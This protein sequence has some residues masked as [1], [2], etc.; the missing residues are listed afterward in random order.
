MVEKKTQPQQLYLHKAVED[1]CY[2]DLPREWQWSNDEMKIFSERKELYQHQID[3]LENLIRALYGHY[4]DREARAPL[5]DACLRKGMNEDTFHIPSKERKVYQV[6]I[7]NGYTTVDYNKDQAD[8]HVQQLFNR[9]CL[10]MATGSGKSLV[11]IKAIALI[12][13]LMG[14]G[15]LPSRGYNIMLLFPNEGLIK[16]T[17]KQ[18]LE[19]NRGKDRAIRPCELSRFNGLRGQLSNDMHVFYGRS[20]LLTEQKKE[21]QLNYRDYLNHGKWYIFMDEAHRGD[22]SDSL[23]KAYVSALSRQGF[24]FNFSATFTEDLD[25]ATT[26]YDLSLHKF[27]E[28]GYGKQIYVSPS[29]FHFSKQDKAPN[30]DTKRKEVL[31]SLMVFSLV[32]ASRRTGTYHAPLLVVLVNKISTEDSDLM[33]FFEQLKALAQDELSDALFNKAQKELIDDFNKKKA[34]TVGEGKLNTATLIEGL[35]KLSPKEVRACV[36]NVQ[37][38]GSIEL[39]E[40][41]AS[42]EIILQLKNAEKPFAL[43]RVGDAKAFK[44]NLLDKFKLP[45]AKSWDKDKEVFSKLNEEE[46][47]HYNLL[48]G[49]RTF[50]EGWDSSRPN[51]INMI[52][53]GKKG[54]QKYIPQ[55]LGRGLRIQPD[56]Q[57]PSARKRTDENSLMETLFVFATDKASVEGIIQGTKTKTAEETAI[58]PLRKTKA[59]FDLLMPVFKNAD[60]TKKRISRFNISEETLSV[61][62]RYMSHFDDSTLLLSH[63]ITKETLD[64]IRNEKGVF[65]L[66][67]E[68]SYEDMKWLFEAVAGHTCVKEKVVDGVDALKKDIIVHFKHIKVAGWS[69]ERVGELKEKIKKEP[70]QKKYG[71]Y[72]IS[73]GNVRIEWLLKQHYYSPILYQTGACTHYIKHI[74]RQE[75]EAKFIAELADWVYKNKNTQGWMF[76]KIDEHLD[77]LSMPYYDRSQNI[78]RNFYPDFIFWIRKGN[79]YR[80]ILVDPKGTAHTSYENK[81]DDFE[82]FF[83]NKGER[84]IFKYKSC[85]VT[86]DLKL[87]AENKNEIGEKYREYWKSRAEFFSELYQDL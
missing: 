73:V 66:N 7:D 51:V 55:A 50:H 36:F 15:L 13:K 46:K 81:V 56:P 1:I 4:K 44:D 20:D 10:W 40:G 26:C 30:D 62:E 5:Y 49:S 27:V 87:I 85:D 63:K 28:S 77:K 38:K 8:I 12:D 78:Y 79:K 67:N 54:A 32:K 17:Q 9:A 72:P 80:I 70:I 39:W 14:S 11:I 57:K 83:G 21:K 47:A 58:P 33:I 34:Y 82:A 37:S 76:S 42:R 22:S 29:T 41:E 86:F 43:I 18:I 2:D 65:Q 25:Y 16:Q 69:K 45:V 24:L 71:K 53:I 61:F 6:Y 74:I 84:K 59:H 3:A 75:S 31:K 60:K 64:T 68:N 52:N 19:Y 35:E 48:I 23:L